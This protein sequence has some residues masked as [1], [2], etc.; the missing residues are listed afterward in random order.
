MGGK[1]QDQNKGEKTYQ[2]RP[3]FKDKFRPQEAKERIEKLV[4]DKLQGA[5]YNA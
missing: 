3:Q 4:K 5:T 2:I 1:K